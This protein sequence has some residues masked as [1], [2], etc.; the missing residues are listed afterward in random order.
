MSGLE[1]PVEAIP[2]VCSHPMLCIALENQNPPPNRYYIRNP[3]GNAPSMT[4]R[5]FPW[6]C[7]LLKILME[8]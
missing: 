2:S 7:K 5:A 4:Y 6:P 1:S 3:K 8:H